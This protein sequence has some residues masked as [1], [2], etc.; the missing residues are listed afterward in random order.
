[1]RDERQV[2]PRIS[3]VTPEAIPRRLKHASKPSLVPR[4]LFS[5]IIK[6]LK[7]ERQLRIVQKH[8]GFFAV[9]LGVFLF[10]SIFAF[11]GLKQV[12][13]ESSFGPY[14]SL[15]F[16]DPGIVLK[17]WNSFLFS[18]FESMPGTGIALFLTAFAFLLLL[19]KLASSS[20]EKFYLV[21]KSVRKQKYE[22]R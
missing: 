14:L 16:S 10:L 21:V 17:Y 2:F 12:L 19:V 15:V 7:L 1:M 11:V 4:G 5:R 22:H 9:L 18:V 8:L 20:L 6:R 13:A 3:P